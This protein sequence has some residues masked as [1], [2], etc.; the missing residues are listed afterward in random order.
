MR[1]GA[2]RGQLADLIQLVADASFAPAAWQGVVDRLSTLAPGSKIVL[3]AIDSRSRQASPTVYAGWTTDEMLAYSDY[4]A[5]VNVFVPPLLASATLQANTSDQLVR[6]ADYESSEFYSDFMV[7]AGHMSDGIGVKVFHS[8][9][10]FAALT[11]NYPRRVAPAY[12]PWF[13]AVL[14]TLGPRIQ[15]ALHANRVQFMSQPDGNVAPVLDMVADPALICTFGGQI[16]EGNHAGR[17][18]VQ[19]LGTSVVSAVLTARDGPFQTALDRAAVRG[20]GQF[21]F[22][23]RFAEE[24]YQVSAIRVAASARASLAVAPIFSPPQRVLLVLSPA[25]EGSDLDT[26][27][28]LGLSRMQLRV[29]EALAAGGTLKDAAALLG[30]SYETARTHLKAAMAKTGTRRQAELLVLIART[31]G[32]QTLR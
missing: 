3:Q 27:K 28:P 26:G 20:V 10:R 21:N 13:Q 8:A 5:G 30:I 18:L 25:A 14:T 22:V 23:A 7:P 11:V 12:E 6:R 17:D 31:R 24:P 15:A 9:E 16:L 19:R 1:A 2:L 32:P 4:Y 29:A